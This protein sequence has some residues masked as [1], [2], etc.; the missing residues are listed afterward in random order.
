[1]AVNKEWANGVLRSAIRDLKDQ[2]RPWGDR[3]FVAIYKERLLRSFGF[4]W[5]GDRIENWIHR[6]QPRKADS[7]R[8]ERPH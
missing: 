7:E 4:K 8:G 1:M 5:Q 3:L 2:R 6:L